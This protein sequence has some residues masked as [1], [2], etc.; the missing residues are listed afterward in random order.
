MLKRQLKEAFDMLKDMG[1]L[2]YFLGIQVHRDRKNR[3]LQIHQR[4]HTNIILKRFNMDNSLRPWRPAQSSANRLT[5][6]LL[7]TKWQ[8]Q[9]QSNVG[10]QMYDMLCTRPNLAYTISQISQFPTN[11]S[12]VHETAA[13]RSL[14]YLNGTRNFGIT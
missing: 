9:Y 6:I 12:T 14:R 7:Q 4:G 5:N 10:S 2:Q 13:K 1:K 3:H 11:P 8:K